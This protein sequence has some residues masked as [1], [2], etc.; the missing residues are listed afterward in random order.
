[1]ESKLKYTPY[2]CEENIWQLAR[3]SRFNG[4]DAKVILITGPGSHRKLW[5]Q[6]CSEDVTQ[7]VCWDYHVVLLV[8]D[9]ISQIWDLD[10]TLDFPVNAATYFRKTFR[11]PD[12]SFDNTNILFRTIDAK[13][14]IDNFSSDRSH[15]R[16]TS[17]DWAA[18][19]PSWPPIVKNEI[20]NLGK[21]L[22]IESDGPGKI[23]SLEQI[24]DF[25]S[26]P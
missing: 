8:R 6:R 1:M 21:W 25:C 7:P 9:N 15:M 19:P 22:D 20:S 13:E 11:G 23:L 5:F 3:H 4:L 12:E 2:Y 24:I 14:Y 18:P 16:L 17:G 10:T 26:S